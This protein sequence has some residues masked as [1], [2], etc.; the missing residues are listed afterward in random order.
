MRCILELGAQS[1]LSMEML[2]RCLLS[3]RSDLRG[4]A[5]PV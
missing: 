4:G 5:L 2:Y 1:Q 3:S